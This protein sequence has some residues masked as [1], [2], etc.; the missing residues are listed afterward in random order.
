MSVRLPTS[1]SL[2]LRLTVAFLGTA[3]IALALLLPLA[4]VLVRSDVAKSSRNQTAAIEQ[5]LVAAVSSGY[6]S[7][8]AWSLEE[9]GALL[10]F[11]T[12]IQARVT[13]RGAGGQ[14]VASNSG[15]VR[16]TAALEPP[17]T[18]PILVDGSRVGTI[19]VQLA[20]NG[21]V[22]SNLGLQRSL[23]FAVSVSAALAV[24]VALTAAILMARRVANPVLAITRAARELTDGKWSARVVDLSRTDELNELGEAF[25][26]L[27]AN[28]ERED[29][30]RRTLTAQIAHEIRTPLAILVVSIEA[31]VDGILPPSLETFQSIHDESVRL[32]KMVEDLERLADARAAR[33]HL[34]MLP[35]DLGQLTEAVAAEL[36]FLFESAGISVTTQIESVTVL[37][38]ERRLRQITSNLLTNAAK[39]TPSGGHVA[40]EVASTMPMEARLVVSDSGIGIEP[41][42]LPYVF[43]S[44]WRSPRAVR[45]EGSGI[46]LAVVKELV[47]AHNG[48]LEV[49]SEPDHG[50]RFTVTLPRV[51]GHSTERSH[52]PWALRAARFSAVQDQHES[53]R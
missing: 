25:N 24:L 51:P 40:L 18:L 6:R 11:A 19:A 44:F 12:R 35:V 33:L 17:A 37:G 16:T 50:S 29:T 31:L 30:V 21:V 4:L 45:T 20:K 22:T 13:I 36:A 32:S 43:E 53:S 42:N 2:R 34:E 47:E 23:A 10:A 15:A 9:I 27:A 5:G 1:R 8:D 3:L 28:L 48:T 39:F 49:A 46:G 26:S 38:D 52:G 41:E 7:R 14:I